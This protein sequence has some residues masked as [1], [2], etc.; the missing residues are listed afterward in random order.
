MYYLGKKR[1]TYRNYSHGEV[2][3]EAGW[4]KER[5]WEKTENQPSKE[6]EKQSNKSKGF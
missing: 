3:S 4:S 5:N 2:F 1:N 6:K